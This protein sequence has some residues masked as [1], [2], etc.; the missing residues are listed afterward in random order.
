[1][2][3]SNVASSKGCARRARPVRLSSGPRGSSPRSGPDRR[4]GRCWRARASWSLRRVRRPRRVSPGAGSPRRG[5]SSPSA[6]AG[7]GPWTRAPRARRNARGAGRRDLGR[8]RWGNRDSGEAHVASPRTSSRATFEWRGRAREDS[9]REGPRHEFR[10]TTGAVGRTVGG[11]NDRLPPYGL[12]ATEYV[13][14]H[15]RGTPAPPARLRALS[16]R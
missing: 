3:A 4:C 8:S 5:R 13:R 15:P 7:P 12:F 11:Q 6:S 10:R 2:R 14:G 16:A 1:M 9:A